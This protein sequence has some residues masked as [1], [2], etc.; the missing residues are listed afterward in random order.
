MCDKIVS[1]NP[2]ML[3]YFPCKYITQKICEEAV[4]NFLPTLSFVPDWFV[5]SKMIKKL[6]TI[7]YA[8]GNISMKILLY[9][10]VMKWVF[11]I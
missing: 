4:D 3:K 7:L 6:F 5:T 11:L 8:D 1:E 2:F 10:I 9:L